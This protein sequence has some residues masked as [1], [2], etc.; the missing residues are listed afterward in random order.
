MDENI[1]IISSDNKKLAEDLKKNK[2]I[3]MDQVY[4]C[5]VAELSNPKSTPRK[6]KVFKFKDTEL[7][8]IIKSANYLANLEN[9][10]TYYINQEDYEKCSTV[11]KIKNRI[12]NTM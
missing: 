3:Y 10:L 6:I 5:F 9:I 12:M 8:V 2:H 11:N 4:N 1:L 7:Q